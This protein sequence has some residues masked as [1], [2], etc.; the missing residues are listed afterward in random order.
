[1]NKIDIATPQQAEQCAQLLQKLNPRAERILTQNSQVDLTKIL[2]TGKFNLELAQMS[3]G[4]LLSLKEP[5]KPETEEYGIGSFVY[6][7]RKPFHPKRLH[8]LLEQYFLIIQNPGENPDE[9]GDEE[10]Q[11]DSTQDEEESRL[12]GEEA[13]FYF[14]EEEAKAIK[15][16]KLQSCYK[17]MF[18]SKGFMWIATRPKNMGEWSQAGPLITISNSGPWFA[19][20]PRSMW[21]QDSSIRQQI[22]K[23][24]K[25][26]TGDR[27]QELVIIG[28][29]THEDQIQIRS[30]LDSCLL[31]S[32][33]MTV[34][35]A[36][37][38]QDWV[39]P[40]EKW[41]SYDNL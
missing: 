40:F 41:A 38:M 28:Q 15:N 36:G 14:D 21:P 32:D 4:W 16:R 1:M 17:G 2:N 5:H 37:K 27:R 33:E 22:L 6:G 7:A 11:D 9:V 35:G 12:D 23:D 18:R 30:D 8:D 31:D 29:F 39:D 13:E 20:L 19:D 24:F 25:M 3:P 34:Y 10:S 26:E